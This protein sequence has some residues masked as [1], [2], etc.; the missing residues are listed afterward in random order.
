MGF[1]GLPFV[2]SWELTLACNLRCRHCASSASELPRVREL[3]LAESLAICDQFPDLLVQEV[4]FTGGE[5]LLQNDWSKITAHLAKLGIR[6]QLLTN[7]LALG[8]DT[9]AQIRDV[10]ITAVGV[11]LDG[12]EQTHDYIRARK[13]LFNRVLAGIDSVLSAGLPITVITTANARNLHEL[14]A[15]LDVLRSA[16]VRRWQIQPVFPLGR[17]NEA[18]E[19]QL[20]EQAYLQLGALVQNLAPQA[21]KVGVKI[22]LADSYGYF[23]EFDP[24]ESPWRGCPAGQVTLGITSDGKVKGCLSLPDDLVEGDLRQNNLWDIWFHPDAFAYIR[25]FSLEELGPN[26]QSCDKADICLGGCS[27][28]SYGSTLRFHNDPYCFY[29]IESRRNNLT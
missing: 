27:A 1:D 4:D 7:G 18:F 26:C 24:R 9:V 13:G 19:L 6:T 12:L 14:P 23:T 28:M 22:E 5:P 17:V 10:G 15:L 2:I 21:Q 20:T 11:S 3:T 8:T 16:G 25:K 29:G